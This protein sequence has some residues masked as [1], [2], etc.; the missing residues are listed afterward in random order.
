MAP[1]DQLIRIWFQNQDQDPEIFYCPAPLISL[2]VEDASL[3]KMP[4]WLSG[5]SLV[6]TH[7]WTVRAIL[8]RDRNFDSG[9]MMVCPIS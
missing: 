6:T 8:G 2:F 4:R 7:C 3:A 5:L 9:I 1:K